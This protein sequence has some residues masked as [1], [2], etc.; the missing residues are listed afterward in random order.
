MFTILTALIFVQFKT[1]GQTDINALELMR[2]DQLRTEIALF[3]ARRE[4]IST[5]LEETEGIIA[6]YEEIIASGAE[7]SELF[8]Q[9]TPNIKEFDSGKVI[10]QEKA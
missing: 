4:E 8:R 2:E 7:A 3:Q 6:Q 1:I 9:G 5:R 10:L